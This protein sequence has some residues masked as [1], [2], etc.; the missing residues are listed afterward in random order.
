MDQERLEEASFRDTNNSDNLNSLENK[1]KKLEY[2]LGQINSKVNRMSE[3]LEQKRNK[4]SQNRTERV[5]DSGIF[6]NIEKELI[7]SELTFKKLLIEKIRYQKEYEKS[8]QEYHSLKEKAESYYVRK[9]STRIKTQKD[10]NAETVS[11]ELPNTHKKKF[12]EID[13]KRTNHARFTAQIRLN[14]EIS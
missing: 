8:V 4:I 13:L 9:D 5:I 11:T 12:L 7:D 14:E 3:N 6:R 2:D 1:F 10:L